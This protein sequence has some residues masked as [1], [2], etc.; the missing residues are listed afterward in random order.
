M[1]NADRTP[2]ISVG[3]RKSCKHHGGMQPSSAQ[4]SYQDQMVTGVPAESDCQG[5]PD[6]RAQEDQMVTGVSLG[7]GS[8]GRPVC[9][10]AENLSPRTICQDYRA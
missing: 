4:S 2:I 6:H 9:D 7:L 3:T 1:K 10:G 8:Q 5:R